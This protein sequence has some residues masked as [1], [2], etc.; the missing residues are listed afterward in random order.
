MDKKFL[1]R[2]EKTIK[3]IRNKLL[4]NESLRKLLYYESDE[5]TEDAEVPSIQLV[6]DNIFLQPVVKIDVNP[7]F[8][9]KMFIAITCPASGFN[10]YNEA[11]HA[12]KVSVMAHDTAWVYGDGCIRVLHMM[13]EIINDLD[14]VKFACA[15]KLI[16]EQALQTTI[17]ETT[18]G[19]SIMFSVTDGVGEKEGE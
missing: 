15:T 17:D 2:L 4:L 10:G 8:N 1:L 16:Y 13:Q 14:H 6:K 11:D 19:Y 7:P 18:G 12:I 9:K 3:E 5:L